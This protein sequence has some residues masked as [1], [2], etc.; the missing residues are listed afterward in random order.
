[1]V[2]S[3]LEPLLVLVEA[4]PHGLAVDHQVKCQEEDDDKYRGQAMTPN[5][6]AFVV[7]HEEA[8]EDL[9]RSVKVDAVA[10][11]DVVII[12]HEAGGGV[13]VPDELPLLVDLFVIFG[14]SRLLMRLPDDPFLRVLVFR[15][16]LF[17]FF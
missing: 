13:V 6:D 4:A 5:V 10:V 8:A 1:M 3:V 17:V 11:S 7:D 16:D 2:N 12:L 15:R 9:L 14:V